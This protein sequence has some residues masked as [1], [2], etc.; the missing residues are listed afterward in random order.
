MNRRT[1]LKSAVMLGMPLRAYAATQ[2]DPVAVFS[3]WLA[4]AQP[5]DGHGLLT[6]FGPGSAHHPAPLSPLA[7][8]NA[9]LF[10]LNTGQWQ[11]AQKIADGFVWWQRRIARQASAWVRGGLPSEI[12]RTAGDWSPG[13]YYYSGDQLVT[14]AALTRAYAHTGTGAYAETALDMARWMRETLFDGVRLN[15]WRRNYGAP[16]VAFTSDGAMV[17][18]IRADTACL[19]L[20]ALKALDPLDRASGWAQRYEVGARFFAGGQSEYGCWYDHFHPSLRRGGDRWCWYGCDGQRPL[21]IG[22]NALR[23]ALGAVQAGATQELEAFLRWLQP[24]AGV[25]LAGYLDPRTCRP[26]FLPGDRPYYD[27]VSTGLLRNL[28]HL[29]G[30]GTHAARCAQ[31]LARLQSPNGGWYWGRRA[32]SLAPLNQEQAVITGVWA[33]VDLVS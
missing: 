7:S 6:Y 21:L 23:S 16:M 17:R 10:F 20:S 13:R 15:V 8:A 1:F 19:W 18:A 31:A 28:Y 25:Y 24:S 9:L 4:G 22:D 11:P 3:R 2:A 30:R 33:S 5:A 14:I 29:L 12:V 32:V 26:A 27:I